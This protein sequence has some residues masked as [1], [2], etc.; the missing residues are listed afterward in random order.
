MPMEVRWPTCR[1]TAP[2]AYQAQRGCE[3]WTTLSRR[4]SITHVVEDGRRRSGAGRSCRGRSRPDGPRSRTC[5]GEQRLVHR[6]V[7]DRRSGDIP[8]ACSTQEDTTSWLS[9]REVTSG[10][11]THAQ[12]CR[13]T[14]LEGAPHGTNWLVGR[15]GTGGCDRLRDDGCRLG[16]RLSDHCR[17]LRKVDPDRRQ[18]AAQ[19][20][21]DRGRPER[22]GLVQLPL[23][24]ME[25][26]RLG[27]EAAQPAVRAD[28]LLERGH[29]AQLRVV[30]AERTGGPAR[31]PSRP[32][33]AGCPP[34]AARTARRVLALDGVGPI[35]R[36]GTGGRCRTRR[37][38][39]LTTGP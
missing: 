4:H 13:E 2:S 18:P 16:R 14:R 37:P 34:C 5:G 8:L 28:Q 23:D 36:R 32:R 39:A 12:A 27:L 3:A 20:P 22:D 25:D 17:R 29:L 38:R 30:L 33:G 15:C 24:R 7:A 6:V 31:A 9:S 1:M 19:V 11:R 10:A 21:V 26:E 35:P